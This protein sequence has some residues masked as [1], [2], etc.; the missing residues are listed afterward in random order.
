MPVFLLKQVH[1]QPLKRLNG[2]YTYAV[3]NHQ[4][5]IATVMAEVYIPC[6]SPRNHAD[7]IA[8]L[9]CVVT[10]AACWHSSG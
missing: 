5:P 3:V 4:A 10:P 2:G 1:V 9:I 8:I 7:Y 6:M